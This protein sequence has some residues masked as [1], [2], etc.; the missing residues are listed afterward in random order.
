MKKYKYIIL[1][2]LILSIGLVGF[3]SCTGDLDRLP[4][5]EFN[6][7][8][9]QIYGAEI[10]AYY[11]GLAK[12]YA[13]YA[14][15]GNE[16]GDGE[17]DV[18]GVD[19]G[20]QASFLRGL[21]NL[22]QLPTDEAHC[23]W[24][25]IGIPDFNNL[26]WTSGNVFIKGLYYRLYYQVNLAN[27]YLRETTEDLL[28]S[29]G[30]S[31][32]VKKEV[33]VLR[34]D[35]RFMRALAYYYLLD[36]FRNVPFVDEN[37]PVG[38]FNPEQIKGNDL[39]SYIE[40]ELKAI[41]GDL[42]D[43]FVGYNNKHYGRVT[44]AAAWSLLSRLYLNAEVYTGSPKYKESAEYAEKVMAVG[45]ELESEYKNMFNVDNDKSKEMIFPIRYMGAETQTWGGMTFIICSTVPSKLQEEVN[46]VGAWQGNKARSSLVKTFERESGHSAD[47]R[48][49]MLKTD[50]TK[51]QEILD[52]T[53]FEDN[54]TPV[55]KFY[56]RHKDGSLPAGGTN[57]VFVDFP[58]FRLAE[59]YLNYAEAVVRDGSAGNK[60]KALDLVNKI[61]Q[62]AYNDK[63]IAPITASQ[64]T[65][66]FILDEKGREFFFEAQRRT[67]LIR[68]GKLTTSSYIWEWK[69]GIKNGKSVDDKYNIFPIPVE[70]LSNPNLTQNT[71]Y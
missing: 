31:D 5:D 26:T 29:R 32:A 33:Q 37:S 16:G 6:K 65:L 56:N 50:M 18:A 34:A 21:W 44:K 15:S 24:N 45:Y 38:A 8:S 52:V 70:D 62:R 48:K 57:I 27:Q 7:S 28:S 25:D 4:D 17:S 51:S 22:Q 11:M 2:A 3:G 23:N 69:G 13:G 30:A 1:Y 64:L 60:D 67:D 12:I 36:M 20:S 41:E 19:G 47:S 14:I 39:F 58:L 35:A 46:A 66:D 55:V 43:S 49:A 10:D 61:R 9:E 71:G 59:V 40:G 68:H 54:G 42:L 63:A 53:A